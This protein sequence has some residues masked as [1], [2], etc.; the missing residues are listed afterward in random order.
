MSSE[1]EESE[2]FVRDALPKRATRGK[3]MSDLIGEAKEADEEF[4]GQKA[5]EELSEDDEISSEEFDSDEQKD[6]E[7]S[8]FD[9]LDE[10][11]EFKKDEDLA[12]SFEKNEKSKKRRRTT[13]ASGSYVDPALKRR[14]PGSRKPKEKRTVSQR[15]VLPSSR[16]LRRST[17]VKTS[18]RIKSELTKKPSSTQVTKKS[19]PIPK[20]TQQ[21]LLAEAAKTEIENKR[22]LT[23]MLMLQ[24]E[25]KKN[26]QRKKV[27]K[28]E[29]RIIFR[30]TQ[31]ANTVTFIRFNELPKAIN[32]KSLQYPVK[33]FCKITGK[34]AKYKDPTSGN[35]YAS[36]EAFK[37][38]KPR[39]NKG[40][41]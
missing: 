3:R 40:K 4:W 6:I 11:A 1:S 20:L 24:E 16:V 18:N 10:E 21:Q 32:Q 8:D 36:V 41:K 29:A 27:N 38:L 15:V 7:D 23:A 12:A 26:R 19:D 17:Q 31:D 14:P 37:K 25:K 39:R 5:W 22:S 35:Y 34:P 13:Q 33:R 9:A 28:E 2:Q 30:S